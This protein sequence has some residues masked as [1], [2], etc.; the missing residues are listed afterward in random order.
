MELSCSRFCSIS[1]KLKGMSPV[2][3]SFK[4]RKFKC[5]IARK[6]TMK[7]KS[8]AEMIMKYKRNELF[9]QEGST[10]ILQD[11]GHL[12]KFLRHLPDKNHVSQPYQTYLCNENHLIAICPSQGCGIN[13]D[14]YDDNYELGEKP[15]WDFVRWDLFLPP[16]F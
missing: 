15:N 10:R 5:K 6:Q 11:I 2:A 12:P 3:V 14:N 16:G 13:N 7:V 9:F 8:V 1:K 4:L